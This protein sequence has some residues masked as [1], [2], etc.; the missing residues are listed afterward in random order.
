M[1]I[2]ADPKLIVTRFLGERLLRAV[3]LEIICIDLEI[4]SR[5][6]AGFQENFL[7]SLVLPTRSRTYS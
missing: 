7:A 2:A 1:S 3:E 6:L 4:E 5:G